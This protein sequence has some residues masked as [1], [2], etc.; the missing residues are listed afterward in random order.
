MLLIAAGLQA[1]PRPPRETR[2]HARQRAL[3]G[4]AARGPKRTRAPPHAASSAAAGAP[5]SAPA[6]AASSSLTRTQG[7]ASPRLA[8]HA[9]PLRLTLRSARRARPP[10]TASLPPAPPHSRRAD[11]A[12]RST[13]LPPASASA[14]ACHLRIL[15]AQLCALLEHPRHL[16]LVLSANPSRRSVP[17]A[18]QHSLRVP[19]QPHCAPRTRPWCPRPC[20]H[21]ATRGAAAAPA[22]TLRLRRSTADTQGCCQKLREYFDCASPCAPGHGRR[23]Q[24]AAANRDAP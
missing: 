3:A 15:S 18:S 22:L 20:L 4:T 17:H 19:A 7:L 10:L 8:S 14:S 24:E 16:P 12:A 2:M 1:R 21:T 5:R 13:R 9:R 6:A 11:H 23:G